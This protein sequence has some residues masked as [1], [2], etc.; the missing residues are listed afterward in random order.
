[1][2]VV[3]Y[4]IDIVANPNFFLL[5]ENI[6]QLVLTFKEAAKGLSPFFKKQSPSDL[7]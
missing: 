7:K 1:M 3:L 2:D 4:I 6:I 5:L